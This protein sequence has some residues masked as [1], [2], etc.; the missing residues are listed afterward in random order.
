MLTVGR[1]ALISG[2]L[3]QLNGLPVAVIIRTTLHDLESR[4]GIGITGGGT[5]MPIKDVIRMAGH[6]NHR[7]AVFDKATGKALELYR[8]K[9]VAS[10]AQRIML[11]ARDGGC[12]KP[13]CAVGA[14]TA[15]KPTTPPETGPTAATPTSTDMTLACGPDNRLVDADGGWPTTINDRGEGEWTPPPDLDPGQTRI[16]YY[17]RPEALLRPPDHDDE[18]PERGP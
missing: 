11:I 9:R 4:A 10:P 16:N 6:A 1:I 5:Q 13:C 8:T 7:L 12:T 14:P 2:D 3:G 18:N 17:H 15:A